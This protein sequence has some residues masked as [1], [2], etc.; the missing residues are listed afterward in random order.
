MMKK[1]FALVLGLMLLVSSAALADE[2]ITV[3]GTAT[4]KLEPDMVMITLG[5]SA[6]NED[7]LA[8]QQE[9]NAVMNQVIEVLTNDMGLPTED[10]ATTEYRINES[11]EYN[12]MKGRSEKIGYSATALLSICV[13]DIDQ[14]GK[15]ID[16]AMNAGANQLNGVEFMSS[17]QRDARDQA[18]TLAVQDGMRKAKVIA[19][20]AGINLPAVPSSIEEASMSTYGAVSNSTYMMMEAAA[21]SAAGTTLQAGMLSVTAKVTITYEID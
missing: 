12:S 10:I 2:Q 3:S 7:V 6:T 18:L 16:A 20:A 21:D 8:A 9:V 5:V 11:Y 14:A 1:I 13:R 17:D 19:T 4:V 15:V